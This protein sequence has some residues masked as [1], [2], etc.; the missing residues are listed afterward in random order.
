MKK[1]IFL[2]MAVTI[3]SLTTWSQESLKSDTLLSKLA[4]ARELLMQG[5]NS[6]ISQICLD[7]IKNHPDNKSAVQWWVIANMERSPDGEQ[8]MES[9]LDSLG[10]VFPANTGI[11]F[12]KAFVQAEY[13]KNEEALS[14]FEKLVTLQP[15]SSVNWIGKGQIS[16]ALNRHEQAVAAFDKAIKLDPKRFDVYNM[17]AIELI[18][19][20]K[21]DE[22]I[23]SLTKGIEI[24]PEFPVNFYN[25]ACVYSLKGDKAHALADL[26]QAFSMNPEFRQQAPK[27][28][29]LKSLWEDEEF[30]N[31]LK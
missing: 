5:K 6:E 17:K 23:A 19:L 1:I 7:I 22:A 18:R 10:K 8:K 25:R 24:A 27:D 14:G 28:E 21:Y 16:G 9:K 4:K 3:F 11:I 31:L 26:R 30:K 15:D 12:F 13:G 20:G 2:F 29:D